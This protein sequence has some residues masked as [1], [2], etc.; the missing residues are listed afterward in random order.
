MHEVILFTVTGKQISVEFNDST[1]YTNYLESG[2]YFVQLID[3]NGNVFT[4]KFIK[5]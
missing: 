2:I 5:S 1:I 4:R 3:V